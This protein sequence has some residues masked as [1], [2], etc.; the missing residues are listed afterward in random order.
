MPT[1]AIE[2]WFGAN[3]G[4]GN[5]TGR[6]D[7]T[8]ENTKYEDFLI[9]EYCIPAK[10]SKLFHRKCR[11]WPRAFPCKYLKLMSNLFKASSSTVSLALPYITK[12]FSQPA[13]PGCF[14]RRLENE[15]LGNQ[16][17]TYSLE[18]NQGASGSLRYI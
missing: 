10:M 5:C 6:A 13:L 15:H 12:N 17:Y 1:P 4:M 3:A 7:N 9:Q 8:Q 2:V 14:M 18:S 16:D 11:K